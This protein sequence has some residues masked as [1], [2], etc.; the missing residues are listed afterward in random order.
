MVVIEHSPFCS[1]EK[2]GRE[3]GCIC[4]HGPV[5][6]PRGHQLKVVGIGV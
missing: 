6:P 5:V 3:A 4:G 2:T 1:G